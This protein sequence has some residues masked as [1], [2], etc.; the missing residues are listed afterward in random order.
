MFALHFP[1]QVAILSGALSSLKETAD[2]RERDAQ[3]W[4]RLSLFSLSLAPE[5][6][7]GAQLAYYATSLILEAKTCQM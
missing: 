6:S 5:P 2:T 3:P 1:G 4:T 7:L